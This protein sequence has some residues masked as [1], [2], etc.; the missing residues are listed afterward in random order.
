VNPI[1]FDLS[2]IGF[3]FLSTIAAILTDEIKES[4][5]HWIGLGNKERL[6][7]H[8]LLFQLQHLPPRPLLLHGVLAIYLI[9][10]LHMIPC[11]VVEQIL[12]IP[13]VHQRNVST[14]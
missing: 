1:R 9:F 12:L 4:V 7:W 8:G 6:F 5:D 14:A 13:K 3:I 11:R 10:N 2:F